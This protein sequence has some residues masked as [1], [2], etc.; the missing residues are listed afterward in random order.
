MV[1]IHDE[2]SQSLLE[3]R[4]EAP[5]SV[6]DR[7]PLA[8]FPSWQYTVD[9]SVVL[10]RRHNSVVVDRWNHEI[11]PP[12]SDFVPVQTHYP[13]EYSVFLSHLQDMLPQGID[14][15]KPGVTF[16][17]SSSIVSLYPPLKATSASHAPS[18]PSL[19][20]QALHG[21]I[22]PRIRLWLSKH[23]DP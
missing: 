10:G 19:V 8:R 20:V 16:G 12:R 13:C 21:P 7:W 14:P 23:T 9:P 6:A 2:H 3:G 22:G 18:G 15:V 5:W 17:S 1:W 11:R 4:C